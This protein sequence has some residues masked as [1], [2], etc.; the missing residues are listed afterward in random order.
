MHKT[1][2][3][4]GML[5]IMYSVYILRLQK[6]CQQRQLSTEWETIESVMIFLYISPALIQTSDF[7]RRRGLIA[8]HR[9]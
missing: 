5:D 7:L 3:K 6:G 4:T 2:K 1:N 9:K 8:V